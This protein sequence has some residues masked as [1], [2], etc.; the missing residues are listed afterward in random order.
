MT[1]IYVPV[2]IVGAPR[3]GTNMLRDV[4]CKI[5]GFKTWPCDEINYIWRHGNIRYPSDAFPPDLAT[6]RIQKFIRNEFKKIAQKGIVTHVV[7]KTCANSLRVEFLDK[8]FPEAKYIFIVR[9]GID[10]V[11]SAIKRW[12][13]NLDIPYILQKVRYVPIT[14]LPFYALRYLNNRL[15]LLLSNKKRLAVWGPVFDNMDS[16]LTD[17]SLEEI[18][19]IQWRQCVDS[20]TESFDKMA[21]EKVHKVRYEDFVKTPSEEMDKLYSFFNINMSANAEITLLKSVSDK[22]VG[23]GHAELSMLGVTERVLP[24]I[25]NTLQQHGYL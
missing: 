14:D 7:E 15:Y 19:A 18:C 21:K 5:E 9:D 23:K 13:A 1:K 6:P 20:A 25:Q 3:S 17:K 4:L 2:I 22:S 16:I 24:F 10:V 12:Q 11:A 8:I